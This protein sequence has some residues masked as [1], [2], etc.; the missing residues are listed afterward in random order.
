MISWP[1]SWLSP[2]NLTSGNLEE[3]FL[4]DFITAKKKGDFF[5]HPKIAFIDHLITMEEVTFRTLLD[6]I[7]YN[8]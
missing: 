6:D 5:S 1:T 2:N 8:H 7:G 3:T 4:I